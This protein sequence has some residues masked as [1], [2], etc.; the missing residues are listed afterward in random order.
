LATTS[1]DVGQPHVVSVKFFVLWLIAS[2]LSDW[3]AAAT[4]L[5]CQKVVLEINLVSASNI[6][7]GENHRFV[8][9]GT[10][11]HSD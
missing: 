10:L 11:K 3:L 4:N 8:S 7:S 2:S 1:K 9:V 5:A 6:M